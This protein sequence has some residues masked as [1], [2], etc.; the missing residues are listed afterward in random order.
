MLADVQFHESKVVFRQGY[1]E[2]GVGVLL[3]ENGAPVP[4]VWGNLF[5]HFHV[6][7]GKRL[8][9]VLKASDF[10]T[11]G[12]RDILLN[13]VKSSSATVPVIWFATVPPPVRQELP[14]NHIERMLIGH[15]A[16]QVIDLQGR[17]PGQPPLG[18]DLREQVIPK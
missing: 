17:R 9:D 5:M 10:Q 18:V 6:H 2:P 7:F 12:R 3:R 8:A 16:G 14:R 15:R 1:S 11:A 13:G 4:I